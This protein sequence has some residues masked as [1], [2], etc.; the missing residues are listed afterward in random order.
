MA[1]LGVQPH[2]IESVLNHVSGSKAGVSGVYNRSPYAT[3]KRSALEL[4]G[5]YVQTLLAK[6]KG[7]NVT[8]LRKPT[9][10]PGV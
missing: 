10:A 7:T 8:M 9:L 5:S 4:W 2:V 1:D 3:E 6:A